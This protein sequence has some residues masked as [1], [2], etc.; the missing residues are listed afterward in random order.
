MRV[1]R[2][3]GIIIGCFILVG[4][5]IY[6]GETIGT[7]QQKID[8]AY[9]SSYQ[10]AYD[11]AYETRYQEGYNEQYDIGYKEAYDKGYDEG[12]ENGWEIGD[13]EGLATR[14]NLHNPIYTELLDFLRHDKTD[15]HRYIKGKYECCDFAADVNNNAELEGIRAAF[16]LI[17]FPEGGHAIVAFETTDRGLIFIEPQADRAA[18]PVIGKHYWRSVGPRYRAARGVDDTVV[19]IQIVW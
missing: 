2:Y 19:E 4:S 1:L 18:K 15:S 16:V 9:N 14:V 11:Q 3:I 7:W 13:E 17:D 8:D 12:Y 10:E 6:L 5:A